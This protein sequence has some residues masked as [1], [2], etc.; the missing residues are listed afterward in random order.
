MWVLGF[1]FFS[2]N[3][4][5]VVFLCVCVCVHGCVH[6]CQILCVE[7]RGQDTGFYSLLPPCGAWEFLTQALRVSSKHLDPLSHIP[8][9]QLF[10]LFL[11]S[12]LDL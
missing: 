1:F 12:E 2:V 6:M 11:H 9:L 8:G 10:L 5:V 3:N 7:V 4:Y